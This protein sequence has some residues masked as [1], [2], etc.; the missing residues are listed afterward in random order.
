MGRHRLAVSSSF[1]HMI[2]IR[3]EAIRVEAL[4]T[5]YLMRKNAGRT[6]RTQL[7]SDR[8]PLA[9][10]SSPPREGEGLIVTLLPGS[11]R[12]PFLEKKKKP[13]SP[14][15]EPSDEPKKYA[16]R[17]P[18]SKIMTRHVPPSQ[19]ARGLSEAKPRRF[20]KKKRTK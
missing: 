20:A 1:L 7:V 11:R 4:N 5:S 10:E 8:K 9:F 17:T 3:V 16:G 14:E 2:V 15:Y 19:L 6:P 13:E 12:D 18:G